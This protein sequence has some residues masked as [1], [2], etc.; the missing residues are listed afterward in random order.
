MP[1]LF[2]CYQQI[3][4]NSRHLHFYFDDNSNFSVEDLKKVVLN[5]SSGFSSNVLHHY[6][7]F[8][9]YVE[10]IKLSPVLTSC[11]RTSCVAKYFHLEIKFNVKKVMFWSFC[12]TCVWISESRLTKLTLILQKYTC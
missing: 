1:K 9:C 12:Y 11:R 7:K 5:Q 10:L 2:S 3:R 4:N 6:V 8:W